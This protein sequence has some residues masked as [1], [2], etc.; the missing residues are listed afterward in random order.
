M[1]RSFR[2]DELEGQF[3]RE[4]DE[5]EEVEQLRMELLRKDIEWLEQLD[6]THRLVQIK[7][8][9]LVSCTFSI[10]RDFVSRRSVF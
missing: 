7:S 10:A 2:Q 6:R 5:H 8:E 9:R 4:V 3:K 1:K